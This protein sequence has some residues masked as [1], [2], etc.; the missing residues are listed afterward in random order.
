MVIDPAGQLAECRAKKRVLLLL[1]LF[2][3]NAPGSIYS[4]LFVKKDDSIEK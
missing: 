4:S 2:F 1:L 3:L